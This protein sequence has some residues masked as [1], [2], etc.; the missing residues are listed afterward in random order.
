MN[1]NDMIAK[2]TP[3]GTSW[4]PVLVSALVSGGVSAGVGYW[5]GRRPTSCSCKTKPPVSGGNGGEKA[6]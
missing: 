3:S 4:L 5:L 6:A 1:E 2:P